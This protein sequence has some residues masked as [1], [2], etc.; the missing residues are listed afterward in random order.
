MQLTS[1]LNVDFSLKCKDLKISTN[2]VSIVSFLILIFEHFHSA[3]VCGLL[4]TVS[5]RR[6]FVS[7]LEPLQ[8]KQC[9]LI[10]LKTKFSRMNN[11]TNRSVRRQHFKIVLAKNEIS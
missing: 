3:E 11:V 8:I 2:Q 5:L 9:S 7:L 4:C 10:I 6:T 1:R